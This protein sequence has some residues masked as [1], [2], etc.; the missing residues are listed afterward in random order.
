MQD[1]VQAHEPAP[2]LEPQ[3]RAFVRRYRCPTTC[4]GAEAVEFRSRMTD[5]WGGDGDDPDVEE[6][7]LAVRG[8][9][10]TRIRVRLL[11]PAGSEGPLPVILYLHGLGAMPNEVCPHLSLVRDLVLGA[12]AVVVVP[13]YDRPEDGRHPAAVER[14]H[15][16]LRWI[17]DG[18]EEAGL[19]GRRI[20]VVGVGAGA[21]HAA[22]TLQARRQG[23]PRLVQQVLVCPVTDGAMDTGSYRR[24]AEGYFLGSEAMR[25]YWQRYA[26]DPG[27]RR[28]GTVSPL[29]A[30]R[31]RLRDMPPAL[32]LTAE[33]DVLR[34]EGEAY[35]TRLREA[36][37]PVVSVRYHGTIH[38]FVLLDPLRGTPPARAARMQ[39]TDTLH[40]ALREQDG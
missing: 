17:A 15:T 32:V 13:E 27:D 34:D 16:V 9:G 24:F 36:G 37:V 10:S 6:E 40:I 30:P 4:E 22:L 7:W 14:A 26:P 21:H 35:A 3:A 33:A 11:R 29:R 18:G 12:D 25:G 19:D 38:G 23:E 2:V 31:G 8:G 20:A 1:D 28:R 5:L 39:I